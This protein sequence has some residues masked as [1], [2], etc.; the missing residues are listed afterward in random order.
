MPAKAVI[1]DL[2]ETLVSEHGV[3]QI[4]ATEVGRQLGVNPSAF[5]TEYDRLR[6][7][8]YTGRTGDYP[9]VIL[10]IARSLKRDVSD[11]AVRR[12]ADDR[13]QAFERHLEAVEPEIEE[14]LEGLQERGVSLALISNTDGS[15][16]ESWFRAPLATSFRLVLFSHIVGRVKPDAEIYRSALS[17]LELAAEECLYVGDGGSDELHGAMAVGL[18]PFCAS[19]F[20]DRHVGIY[21]AEEIARRKAGFPV[22]RKPSDV[23]EVVT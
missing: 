14:M 4:P 23:L 8:R 1:F 15:E 6:P 11:D 10:R 20:L 13:R 18:R 19:W 17:S 21:G 22:L 9:A 3:G 16:V 2:F 12:I 5:E 7:A